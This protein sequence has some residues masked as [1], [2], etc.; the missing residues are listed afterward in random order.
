MPRE[1]KKYLEY[2]RTQPCAVC[3]NNAEPHH[4][5]EQIPQEYA[6]GMGLKPYDL[7][8]IPLCRECHVKEHMG[9]LNINPHVEVMKH[10]IRYIESEDEDV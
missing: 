8:T 9:D 10:L 6:G 2:I 4:V 5:R 3:G 7:L 1:N